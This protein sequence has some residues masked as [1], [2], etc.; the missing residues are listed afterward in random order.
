MRKVL[1]TGATG[2][3]GRQGLDCLVNSDFDLAI[4][5][6]ARPSSKNRRFLLP[7]QRKGVEVVW[8]DLTVYE[9][10]KR[11]VDDI[12][13]VLH[14]GGMV[15]PLAD[16]MPKATV[17]IN[18]AAMRNIV[19]AIEAL[20]QKETTAVVYIGSVAQYGGKYLDN[21]WGEAADSLNAAL[22]DAYAYSKIESERILTE[23]GIRRWVSLRQ[24]GILHP[25]LL[26][27]TDDPIMY[28]VPLKGV[29]E[30][31]TVED[32]GRLLER[33]CNPDL[34]DSFWRRFYNISSGRSYR[35]SNYE[36]EAMILKAVGCPPPEKIFEAGWFA[37]ANFHGMWYADSDQLENYL[38]FR[39]NIPAAEYFSRMKKKLPWF[40][41]LSSLVP[42]PVIKLFMK[43]V[44]RKKPLGT[45]FWLEKN[46]VERLD[47]FF[48]GRDM[49]NSIPQWKNIPGLV[50]DD[51]LRDLPEF[52]KIKFEEKSR[53]RQAEEL[54]YGDAFDICED[55]VCEKGHAYR[56][57]P[58]ARILG[59]HGCPKCALTAARLPE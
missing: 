45:L 38:H 32:S 47:A 42:S 16:M 29:L 57:T 48:G 2:V 17:R 41:S 3:M 56:L 36:F 59:G 14:V 7:Y 53:M 54:R 31:A 10:V 12:D 9:D 30:W 4:R 6:L 39:E 18:V 20:S 13:I 34:P 5:V 8:G 26:F 55:L 44:A 11:A 35:L 27:K 58:R 49:C 40:F 19:D 37:T 24:T 28:H 43:K 23:S 50:P 46:D 25:G 33:V 21:P 1:L 51:S 22:F 15:S 52:V